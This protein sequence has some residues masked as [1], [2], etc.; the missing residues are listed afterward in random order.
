MEAGRR[1]EGDVCFVDLAPVRREDELAQTVLSALGLRGGSL[2]PAGPG[3]FDDDTERLIT[4]LAT[5]ELLLI[6]DNCEQ[7]VAEVA[8]LTHRL[9]ASC[10]GVR[11]LA[12]SREALGITGESLCPV[13]RLALPA[14]DASPDEALAS[15]AVRLFADRAAAVRPDFVL[16]AGTVPIVQA[17]CARARRAAARDRTRR[18]PGCV[19]CRWRRSRR[20]WTTGSGCCRAATGPR[21]RG[22]RRCVRWS[23]GAGSLDEAEQTLARR[24]TV[25]PGGATIEAA[26][27]VCGVDE[28]EVVDLLADLADKSLIEPSGADDAGPYRYR[29][30]ETIRLYG[31]ERLDE[32]G[33]RAA[34]E[35]AHAAYF[36]EF[37][38]HAEPYLRTREQLEWLARLRAEHANLRAA[39]RWAVDADPV[40]RPAARRGAGLVLVAARRALRSGRA[41]PRTHREDRAGAAGRPDRGVP[42]VPH[43]RDTRG[44]PGDRRGTPICSG[45]RCR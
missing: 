5:R 15:P 21:R 33:E 29:M 19:R 23:S 26:A 8:R 32:A 1:A 40:G 41:E 20:G 30:F 39:V 7:V 31:A 45:G 35:K 38:D 42:D 24:L 13:P 10:P 28:D 34:L 44:R 9:L 2:M 12:T 22:T 3:Q 25:F 37:A 27:R 36:L 18:R 14:P 4:G 6:L 11:V 43:D 16:D 17:V